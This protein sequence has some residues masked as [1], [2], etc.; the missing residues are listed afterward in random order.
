MTPLHRRPPRPDSSP[1]LGVARHRDQER[2]PLG[3]QPRGSP[4]PGLMLPSP[5]G[6]AWLGD[7]AGARHP[8]RVPAG[9]RNAHRKPRRCPGSGSRSSDHWESQGLH[10]PPS[11]ATVSIFS[12][13][14]KSIKNLVPNP[15]ASRPRYFSRCVLHV[16]IHVSPPTPRGAALPS[17]PVPR[18][19]TPM[20]S[21]SDHPS[22]L[23]RSSH[24]VIS[25]R[26]GREGSCR[27][28]FPP[29]SPSTPACPW[30]RMLALVRASCEHSPR[31]CRDLVVLRRGCPDAL[32]KDR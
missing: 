2:R 10:T 19:P 14:V 32:P 29:L 18:A 23:L 22:R 3:S 28:E 6:R 11:R 25:K 26:P 24:E 4:A 5:D 8:T 27:S 9:P 20:L 21:K 13:E 12:P 30:P 1:G 31:S 16:F 17:A 15:F 7:T